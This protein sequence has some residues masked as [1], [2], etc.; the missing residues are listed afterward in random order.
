M[1]RKPKHHKNRLDEKPWLTP[2]AGDPGKG[3]CEIVDPGAY[4]EALLHHHSDFPKA[5]DQDKK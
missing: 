2:I 1:K 3:Q 4:T 5:S